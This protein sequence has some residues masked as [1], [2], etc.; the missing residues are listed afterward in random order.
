M[1]QVAA[2]ELHTLLLLEDGDVIAFGDNTKGQCNITEALKGKRSRSVEEIAAGGNHSVFLLADGSVVT[3]GDNSYG[4]RDVPTLSSEVKQVAAGSLHTALVLKDGTAVAFGSNHYK[5]CTVPVHFGANRVT[6]VSAV[7]MRT[8]LVYNGNTLEVFG[9]SY[10][11]PWSWA[12]WGPRITQVAIGVKHNVV[13]LEDGQ[14]IADGSPTDGRCDVPTEDITAIA[15]RTVKSIATGAHHTVLVLT[16]G[17]AML[18]GS[19][20]SGQCGE[21]RRGK[22]SCAPKRRVSTFS[23]P[24]RNRPFLEPF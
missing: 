11:A 6:H 22:G 3:C 15:G 20:D 10:L 1:K 13:L 5:Q 4:Q 21:G 7:C 9:C 2:G 8:A 23:V 18:F 19:N 24:S 17:T 14:V 16:D 12:T